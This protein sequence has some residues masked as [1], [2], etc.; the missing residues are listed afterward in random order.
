MCGHAWLSEHHLR[1]LRSNP[2]QRLLG[3][4]IWKWA[5]IHLYY[6]GIPCAPSNFNHVSSICLYTPNSL[7]LA[8]LTQAARRVAKATFASLEKVA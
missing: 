1:E 8:P 2:Q 3:A 4:Y 6:F 5:Y 7:P